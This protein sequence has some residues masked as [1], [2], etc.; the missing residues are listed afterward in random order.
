MGTIRTPDT[1]RGAL[2]RKPLPPIASAGRLLVVAAKR[3]TV[4]TLPKCSRRERGPCILGCTVRTRRVPPAEG[5][6][7]IC[8]TKSTSRTSTPLDLI[9]CYPPVSVYLTPAIL[10][11]PCQARSPMARWPRRPRRRGTAPPSGRRS[12]RTPPRSRLAHRG[13]GSGA[14]PCVQRA[15][16]S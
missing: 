7:A 13:P 10:T 12:R 3:R 6:L 4:S 9:I 11:F 2:V 14:C 8:L 16:C 1:G 15:P 5:V